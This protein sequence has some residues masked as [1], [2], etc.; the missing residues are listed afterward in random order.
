MTQEKNLRRPSNGWYIWAAVSAVMIVGDIVAY[1]V[2]FFN[3]FPAMLSVL[4]AIFMFSG[5][6]AQDWVIAYYQERPPPVGR[7]NT[8]P[9]AMRYHLLGLLDRALWAS[10]VVLLACSLMF[11][12]D[13]RSNLSDNSNMGMIVLVL[14]A[15][16]IRIFTAAALFWPGS[17][18]RRDNSA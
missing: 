6:R 3:I 5:K 10:W 2:R 7:A 17:N 15:T 18:G 13:G 4:F 11:Q 8:A 9:L 1:G 16:P 14:A 12:I